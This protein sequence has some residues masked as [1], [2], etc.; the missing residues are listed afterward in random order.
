MEQ[1]YR[2]L[3]DILLE[4]YCIL[5]K[6]IER[7][8]LE[9]VWGV[10]SHRKCYQDKA[11]HQKLRIAE[12]QDCPKEAESCPPIDPREAKGR[13]INAFAVILRGK[14]IQNQ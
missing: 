13:Q 9:G 8:V 3:G 12:S 4:F 14:S 5:V 1:S 11:L 10:P 2:E 7:S 6:I